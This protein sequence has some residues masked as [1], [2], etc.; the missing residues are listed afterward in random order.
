[1]KSLEIFPIP[2]VYNWLFSSFRSSDVLTLGKTGSLTVLL[3]LKFYPSLAAFL[4]TYS[5]L[6]FEKSPIDSINYLLVIFED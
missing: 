2:S 3:E 4:A 6:R 1:M 5:Y